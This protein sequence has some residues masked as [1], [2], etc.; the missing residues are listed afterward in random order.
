[1]IFI[2][3]SEPAPEIYQHTMLAPAP[4][5]A[6]WWPLPERKGSIL[7]ARALGGATPGA[8]APPAGH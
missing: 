8:A 6:R 7:A 2:D 5:P 1:M 3:E 4:P